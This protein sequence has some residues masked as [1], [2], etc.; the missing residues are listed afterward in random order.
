MLCGVS[1]FAAEG[2][3]TNGGDENVVMGGLYHG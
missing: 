1:I 3:V 2:E